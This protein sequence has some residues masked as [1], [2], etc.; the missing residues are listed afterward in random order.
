[1]KENQGSVRLLITHGIS[2]YEIA[3]DT[4]SQIENEIRKFEE[5]IQQAVKEEDWEMAW[6][7]SV[8]MPT[9]YALKRR[10]ERSMHEQEQADQEG[11]VVA[12]E[13]SV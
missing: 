7:L 2:T 9:L 1:M 13:Q 12:S 10:M 5:K 11:D 4:L 8:G 6:A 3:L